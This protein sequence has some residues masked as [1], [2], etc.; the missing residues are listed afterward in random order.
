MDQTDRLINCT[1]VSDDNRARSNNT[2]TH[3]STKRHRSTPAIPFHTRTLVDQ[4]RTPR[5]RPAEG[6][7]VCAC[8][9]MP[10]RVHFVHFLAANTQGGSCGCNSLS[11]RG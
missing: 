9:S 2:N 5:H 8:T 1:R 6:A 4:D 11:N 7:C 10:P 3:T